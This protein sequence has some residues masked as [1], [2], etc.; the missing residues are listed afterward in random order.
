MYRDKKVVVVMPAYNAAKTL[1]QTY[2]EVRDQGIVDQIILVDDGSRD[3][4]V[5]VARSLQGVQ[6]HRQRRT[7]ATAAIKRPVTASRSKP[8]RTSS[9]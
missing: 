8:A 6:V 2:A 3:E 7:T 1:P 4:T 5:D 9:S